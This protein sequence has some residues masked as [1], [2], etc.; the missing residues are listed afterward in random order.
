MLENA[1]GVPVRR[2]GEPERVGEG[3]CSCSVHGG[4]GEGDKGMGGQKGRA[5][6]AVPPAC[7]WKSGRVG[8]VGVAQPGWRV[9]LQRWCQWALAKAC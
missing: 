7:V 3:G 5:G 2:E 4:E 9:Y 1:G 8:E 6:P